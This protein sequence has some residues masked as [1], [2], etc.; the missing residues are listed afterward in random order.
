[1]IYNLLLLEKVVEV[2]GCIY[3]GANNNQNAAQFEVNP[4]C[5][6]YEEIIGYVECG[7]DGGGRRAQAKRSCQCKG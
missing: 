1:M 7:L 5:V 3:G 2:I 6:P 4:Y